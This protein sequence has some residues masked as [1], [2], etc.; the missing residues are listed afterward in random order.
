M[1]SPMEAHGHVKHSIR[2]AAAVVVH[3]VRRNGPVTALW[4]AYHKV[5]CRCVCLS[6]CCV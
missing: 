5:S 2:A 1:S 4:R 6:V 3:T